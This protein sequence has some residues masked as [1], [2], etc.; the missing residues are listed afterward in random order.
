[1]LKNFDDWNQLKKQLDTNAN[2]PFFVEREIWWCSVGVNVGYEIL[3]KGGVYSRPML[4][5]RKLGP[6]TFIGLPLTSQ[7][8]ENGLYRHPI[9]FEGING[10]VLLDQIRIVDCRR[11]SEKMGKI[12][13]KR[14]E[15]I[16]QAAKDLL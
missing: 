6:F 9:T 2:P 5:L 11:L 3:G 12:G 8:K 10:D 14:Y 16:R 7:R 13:K 1:M 15:R 4:V